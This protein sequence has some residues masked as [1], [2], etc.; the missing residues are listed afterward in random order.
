MPPLKEGQRLTFLLFPETSESNLEIF[1]NPS[2]LHPETKHSYDFILISQGY[3]N[4]HHAVKVSRSVGPFVTFL[5]PM[6]F[7]CYCSYPTIPQ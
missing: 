7:L 6:W 5:N 1:F 4:L 2:I 3:P